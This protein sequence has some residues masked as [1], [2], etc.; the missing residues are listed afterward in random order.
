M[1][2]PQEFVV[3]LEQAASRSPSQR[4]ATLRHVTDLFVARAEQFSEEQI[5]LFDVVLTRLIEVI[6]TSALAELSRRL[7]VVP[8]APRRALHKLAFDD[9]IAV[10]GPVLTHSERLDEAELV[11]NARSKS[12][13]HLLA[14]S[15]RKFLPEALTDILLGRGNPIVVRS[16]ADNAGARFSDFGYE[17]L[18]RHSVE[19]DQLA[20]VVAARPELPRHLFLR[21]V[22]KASETV[23]ARL[24]ALN[25]QAAGEIKTIVAEVAARVQKKVDPHGRDYTA[26]RSVVDLLRAEGGLEERAVLAFAQAG[27]CEEVTAALAVLAELPVEAVEQAMVQERPETVLI[28]TKAIGFSWET[29]KAILKARTPGHAASAQE[30]DH[31]LASFERLKHSTAEQ[32]LK[33]H[34]ARAAAAQRPS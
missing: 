21:L 33:F 1:T 2:P 32:I 27:R 30:L 20:L 25:P 31:G 11:T 10:A 29:V 12:Q 9:E 6:E 13:D 24:Q 7:A 28:I 4:G 17:A 34:R 19:D 26:A 14:I 22:A 16:I 18:I 8:N 15:R 23:R 5:E 3:E